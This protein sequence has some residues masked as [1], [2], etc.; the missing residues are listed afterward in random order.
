MPSLN[1]PVQRLKLAVLSLD[2]P[3]SGFLIHS[4][5]IIVAGNSEKK[6]AEGLL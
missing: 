5:E 1:V 3:C 4:G 6:K 2:L